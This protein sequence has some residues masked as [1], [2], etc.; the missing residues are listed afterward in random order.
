M[1][2][3][4][5]AHLHYEQGELAEAVGAYNNLGI[6]L[7]KQGCFEEAEEAYKKAIEID[8]GYANAYCNYGVLL[9]EMRRF[10]EAEAM[11]K[12]V[13]AIEPTDFETLCNLALL[14][15]ANGQFD[16][17]WL[18]YE[19][20]YSSYKKVKIVEKPSI[21]IPQ[22]R[23][24]DVSGKT[25][26][27]VPEQGY[28]D[29]IQFVRFVSLLK[30]LGAKVILQCRPEVKEL[31]RSLKDV[32]LLI[33]DGSDAGD[34]LCDFW[35][36]MMS[37]PRL[38]HA[39]VE[40]FADTVPYLFAPSNKRQAWADKIKSDTFKVGLAYKGSLEHE[41]DKNR[42]IHDARLLQSLLAVKGATFF[43][44]QKDEQD[45]AITGLPPTRALGKHIADFSDA[46][47]II[48]S[49]DLLICVDTAIAHL[50][51]AMGKKCWVLLPYIGLDWRWALY[52][53]YTPWYPNVRL[54]KQTR[55][56]T[57]EDVL[58]RVTLALNAELDT[59]LNNC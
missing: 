8:S 36:F 25:V 18:L 24:E 39:K 26:L 5:I 30:R 17:G 45:N 4:D 2:E 28:G 11:Y 14:K 12:K 59:C 55:G 32:D 49:L 19:S 57:W 56:E 33:V 7:Q 9:K 41:N 51:G 22:W 54:F 37:M 34:V 38:L 44:L 1:T 6:S 29:E 58:R 52:N 20:R 16:E 15:L 31:F 47:A 35:V 43:S 21:S 42:S 23:G 48:G 40:A 27:V 53:D 10:E 13:L 3:A 50:A 46:A